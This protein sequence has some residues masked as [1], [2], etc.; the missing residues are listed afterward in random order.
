[1]VLRQIAC[2]VVSLSVAVAIGLTCEVVALSARC[3][4]AQDGG[5][6]ARPL[7][8]SCRDNIGVITMSQF[9][10]VWA[11]A[12]LA[13]QQLAFNRSKG[14]V[15][16]KHL[17]E[18][19]PNDGMVYYERGEAYEYLKVLDRA[20]SDYRTAEGLF[21]LKHW[22]A[23]A[24]EGLARIQHFRQPSSGQSK[25]PDDT[26]AALI[27]RLHS[28]PQLAHDIRVD[29]FSAI[30]KFDSEPHFAAAQL[31]V[32]YTVAVKSVSVYPS[33]ESL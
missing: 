9:R 5:G 18:V 4:S 15:A 7:G 30:Q 6:L 17:F 25:P 2:R 22:K 33:R 27:H 20:E 24:R 12:I 10:K 26:Q 32:L 8:R 16:F 31:R 14:E 19:Y 11:D 1:V 29:A 23:I 3:C 13:N 21:P 28:V